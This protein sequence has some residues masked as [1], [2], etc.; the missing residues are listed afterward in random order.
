MPPILRRLA[1][2]AF[3]TVVLVFEML[4]QLTGNTLH[5][6]VGAAFFICI[7]A[8]LVLARRWIANIVRMLKT[9]ELVK[10]QKRLA[11]I[12][13]LLALDMLLLIT[14]SLI[15]SQKLWDAGI[16]FE[17]LNPGNIWYPI[18]TATAYALCVL[19][20]A[21]LSMHWKTITD[22]LKVSYDPSKRESISSMVNGLAMIGSIALGIG[23][24]IRAGSQA[25]DFA[26]VPEDAQ[27]ASTVASGYR[28]RVAETGE[29][30]TDNS[31]EI[32]NLSSEN[33][34]QQE[35]EPSEAPDE[36]CPLCPRRCK[37]SAPR[38]ERP[39]EAGLI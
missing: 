35:T 5:E 17:F 9:G 8:H 36:I 25:S 33:A 34:S 18:H 31:F 30:V 4:Y 39:Y 1:F 13:A 12:A 38:C 11:A 27:P 29:Y 24:I 22:S 16:D 14:S 3:L 26:V 23:G 10:R 21:H 19:V 2:D 20:L 37:L 28:E 15:I 32:A 7:I 6:V